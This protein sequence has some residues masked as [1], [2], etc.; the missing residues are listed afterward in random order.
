MESPPIPRARGNDGRQPPPSHP[1]R[2]PASPAHAGNM[3]SPAPSQSTSASRRDF[4]DI[5]RRGVDGHNLGPREAEFVED[6]IRR[7]PSQDAASSGGP[8]LSSSVVTLSQYGN[9]PSQVGD[10]PQH[11]VERKMRETWDEFRSQAVREA[12]REVEAE[13]E[14]A[15]LREDGRTHPRHRRSPC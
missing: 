1:A 13:A 9:L 7:H 15:R 5:V 8:P 11:L 3:G 10:V 2:P 6:Y 12:A 4:L 14:A